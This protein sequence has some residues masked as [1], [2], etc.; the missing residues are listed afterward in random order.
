MKMRYIGTYSSPMSV[1]TGH[2][3]ECTG[4]QH[5]VN[6]EL[7]DLKDGEKDDKKLAII[8]DEDEEEYLYPAELFEIVEE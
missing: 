2:I 1:M 3:Y 4:F 6:G 5:V 8:I 7:V